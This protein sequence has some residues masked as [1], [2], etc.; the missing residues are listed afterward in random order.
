MDKDQMPK[1]NWETDIDK[2]NSNNILLMKEIEKKNSERVQQLLKLK[3]SN[4]ILGSI[5]GVTVLSIYC[6]TIYTVK[7][8]KFLD[9]FNEPEKVIIPPKTDI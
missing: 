8:E 5:L 3:R 1:V 2:I 4:K 7:Q 9:D 6:Y